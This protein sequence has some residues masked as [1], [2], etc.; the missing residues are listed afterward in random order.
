VFRF[1]RGRPDPL[2]SSTIGRYFPARP[3]QPDARSLAEFTSGWPLLIEAQR[4]ERERRGRVILMTTPLDIDWGNLPFSNFYLPFMQSIVRYLAGGSVDAHN[5]SPGEPVVAT[6][7]T[8]AV[9][10]AVTILPP[11]EKDPLPLEVTR[12]GDQ[13]EV[14]HAATRRPG[15]YRVL[16]PE[17]DGK[18]PRTIHYVV[19]APRDESNLAQLTNDRWRELSRALGFERVEAAEE[20]IPSVMAESRDGRE[21]W[22]ALLC[23]ALAL[24]V[25][26]LAMARAFTRSAAGSA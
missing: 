12:V 8:S 11:G 9:N 17:P 15:N 22:S 3:R 24:A 5:L 20:S 4:Q 16:V 19:T 21:L 25:L 23:A 1:L 6:L 18:P 14:R 26:E 2:P 13:A 7:E 10:R